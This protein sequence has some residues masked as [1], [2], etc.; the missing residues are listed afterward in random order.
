M[1]T[2]RKILE[3]QGANTGNLISTPR[4]D[5]GNIQPIRRGLEQI[6]T[7]KVEMEPKMKISV[8]SLVGEQRINETG[9]RSLQKTT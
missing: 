4:D 7:K 6:C 1:S 3:L 2:F 8:R 5:F 9:E